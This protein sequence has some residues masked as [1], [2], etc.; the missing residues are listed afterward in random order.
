MFI[1]DTKSHCNDNYWFVHD[2]EDASKGKIKYLANIRILLSAKHATRKYIR[3][4]YEG[5]TAKNEVF[6][7]MSCQRMTFF[8][9]TG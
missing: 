1:I 8:R 2:S 4:F 9:P 5:R 6:E 7:K 3:L